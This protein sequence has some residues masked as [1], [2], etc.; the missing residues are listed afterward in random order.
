MIA[1]PIRDGVARWTTNT[2]V[3]A[4]NAADILGVARIARVFA[5]PCDE[6]NE[7]NRENSVQKLK[8]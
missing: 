4:V 2:L 7:P 5:A 3:A 6:E 8:E 1:V